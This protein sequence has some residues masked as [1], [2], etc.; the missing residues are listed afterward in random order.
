MAGAVAG[1]SIRGAVFFLGDSVY[2]DVPVALRLVFGQGYK[3]VAHGLDSVEKGTV[4]YA[5]TTG[6]HGAGLYPHSLFAQVGELLGDAVQVFPASF[7]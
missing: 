3:C 4:V 6:R 2:G 5:E 1:L 7:S